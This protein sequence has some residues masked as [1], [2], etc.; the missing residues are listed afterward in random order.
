LADGV[1]GLVYVDT[2][3][4]LEKYWAAQSGLGWIGKHTNLIS[5]TI[6]SWFFL[7]EII[8]NLDLEPDSPLPD[9]C[10]TCT[11]CIDACPT[12]A[13][14][15]PYVLDSRRCISYLTIE[16]REDTPVDLRPRL[17]NLVFGC[18]IC[19][20]VC[21]WNR[22]VAEAAS[23]DFGRTDSSRSLK[24]LARITPEEFRDH[25]NRTPL[26]R[27][28]WRGFMRNVA[29]ALGNEGDDGSVFELAGLLN[30]DDAM[31]RRHAA[32]ALKQI[33]SQE[34][35]ERLRKRAVIES[36]RATLALLRKLAGS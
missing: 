6:G 23:D 14:V 18:D 25:F 27:C 31:V 10:G 15:E 24:Q 3:P 26:K 8:L 21:P 32:W 29:T 28:Q 36:D 34:A 1:E 20:D 12:S 19:Q 22:K 2:G 13:I 33:A 30:S 5:R 9:H 17:G 4:I 16:L 35:L 7:G 11:A